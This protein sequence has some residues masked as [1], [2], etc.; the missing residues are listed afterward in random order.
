MG[1]FLYGSLPLHH[2]FLLSVEA[3]QKDEDGQPEQLSQEIHFPFFLSRIILLIIAATQIRTARP[4]TIVPKFSFIKSIMI[5][6]L[7]ERIAP[8]LHFY[9]LRRSLTLLPFP[10]KL[11]RLAGCQNRIYF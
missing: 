7:C 10:V 11:A 6:S 5:T 4:T 9:M 3:W 8:P 2:G 1:A